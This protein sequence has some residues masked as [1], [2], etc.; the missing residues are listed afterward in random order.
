MRPVDGAFQRA[1]LALSLL[2]ASLPVLA[3]Q[4]GDRSTIEGTISGAA[5][6][7]IADCRVVVRT[8]GDVEVFVSPPSDARGR[9]AVAVP[10]G[11]RY[12]IAALILAS[13]ERVE[14]PEASVFRADRRRL[15]RDLTVDFPA[16]DRTRPGADRP[17]GA[18]RLFLSFVEDPARVDRQ[19][20]EMQIGRAADNDLPDLS[21]VRI[22]AA[23]TFWELPQLEIGGRWGAGEIRS[24][25]ATDES[26]ALDVELWAKLGLHRSAGGRWNLAA[27][28]LMK[29]PAGDHDAG[30]GQGAT[31]SEWFVAASRSLSWGVLVG[32]VGVVTSEDGEVGG[33]PL[34]GRVTGSS[35]L[36]LLI[37]V[38][39]DVGFVL[40]ATL[41]GGRFEQT[42]SDSRVLA[43]FTWRLHPRGQL[44]GAV[45][46]GLADA[47]ADSE[48]VAGYAFAF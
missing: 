15:E 27:G 35:G 39:S 21:A 16:P 28:A 4:G 5:G 3:A 29:L 47:S 38:S 2:V 26:G 36:G 42:A 9:Y 30:L 10:F 43:G 13:G 24:G 18:D 44:R 48:L 45:A 6:E 37:P 11:R 7:P 22:V 17:G 12:V 40:E 34:E 20:W 14:R 19:R 46:A 25:G 41:D 33:V 31:Q 32:H 1:L 23:F 8:A